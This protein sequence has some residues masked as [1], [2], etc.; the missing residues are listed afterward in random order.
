M[1]QA[2]SRGLWFLGRAFTKK[3]IRRSFM[4]RCAVSWRPSGPAA[5]VL[6][7][8]LVPLVQRGAEATTAA[9]GGS[10]RLVVEVDQEGRPS[11]VARAPMMR[12]A[13][14]SPM[15]GENEYS[16]GSLMEGEGEDEDERGSL[17]H[18]VD[19]GD[20]LMEGEG[21]GEDGWLLEDRGEDG[22]LLE[23]GDDESSARRR[24]SSRRRR[25]RRRAVPQPRP[26]NR[27]QTQ[28]GYMPYPGQCADSK[29]KDLQTSVQKGVNDLAKCQGL[30]SANPRCSAAEWY[31]KSWL[32]SRCHLVLGT[33]PAVQGVKRILSLAATC[34][35]KKSVPIPTPKPTPEPTPGLVPGPRGAVGAVGAAGPVGDPGPSGTVGEKG[36]P[37]PK[38][39]A[40]ETPEVS[41]A[42]LATLP[43]L[44]G[45][46]ALFL[47]ALLVA[48][49]AFS[50]SVLAGPKGST[51]Q[52]AGQAEA[53]D[54]DAFQ[55]DAG[56]IGE[57][58]GGRGDGEAH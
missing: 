5:L 51:R 30:C 24:G 6:V 27:S 15:E 44:G 7:H 37:G 47:V 53:V 48:Y 32:F 12:R 19:D 1:D 14:D 17:G 23:G 50:S 43:I 9:A 45:T 10:E 41:V 13:G 35:V 11:T 29:K 22:S 25:R 38:G 28:Y 36:P 55:A 57:A 20:S 18:R 52:Q 26:Q 34:F 4:P 49:F 58:D 56:G 33:T 42:G 46:E 3:R 8:V 16:S 31:A 39:D 21:E 40:G 54:V 2:W